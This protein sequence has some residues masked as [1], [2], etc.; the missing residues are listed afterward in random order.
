MK[1]AIAALASAGIVLFAGQAAAYQ[2]TLGGTPLL[3]EG[4]TTSEPGVTQVTSFNDGLLPASY[5][6]GA[7]VS[8][9][10]GAVHLQPGGD[11]SSYWTIGAD[12][13]GPGVVQL[14][15]L[16]NYFGMHWGTMDKYN[17]LVL[18]RDGVDLLSVSGDQF[19]PTRDDYVN[20]F[21]RNPGEYFDKVT[22]ISETNA[23]ESDNHAFR[24]VPEPSSYAMMVAGLLFA[25]SIARRRIKR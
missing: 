21:A 23:F 18:S 10:V 3:N 4:L 9:N 22:F 25:G 5:Q 20:I 19:L 15:G 1:H 7:V 17:R 11:T 24:L 2:L 14:P 6:G 13:P 16:A 12:N 8:G